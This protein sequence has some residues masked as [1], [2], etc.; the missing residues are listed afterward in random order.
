MILYKYEFSGT[1]IN[2]PVRVRRRFA[3]QIG[4]HE[5]GERATIGVFFGGHTRAFT[6]S[7]PIPAR[8][9][10]QAVVLVLLTSS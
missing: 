7:S 5:E 1:S 3:Q 8:K 10:K 6:L 4:V 9:K 2:S